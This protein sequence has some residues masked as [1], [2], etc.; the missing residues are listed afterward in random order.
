MSLAKPS[1]RC[2]MSSNA[3]RRIS[4]RWRG[5][6]PAQAGS[7]RSAA[8]T[9][10]NPSSM[11]AEATEVITSSEEGS[12]TSMVAPSEAAPQAPSMW[13]PVRTGMIGPRMCRDRSLVEGLENGR[14]DARRTRN[15]QVLELVGGGQRYMGRGDSRNRCIQI[16]EQFLG[17]Q[18]RNLGT[19]TAQPRVFLD[20]IEPPRLG[21][22]SENRLHVQ[23]HQRTDIDHG[24]GD[25]MFR[26]ELFGGLQCARDH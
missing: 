5:A 9:A 18:A 19:P 12:S 11:L 22:R 2:F 26:L 15:G 3:R 1:A 16:P 17:D 20:R 4:A 7:A 25:A 10:A 24:C 23:R 21:D 6:V 14:N 8:S 13:S